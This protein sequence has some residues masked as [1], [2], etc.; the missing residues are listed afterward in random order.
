MENGTIKPI[1]GKFA[2][3]RS[4][5]TSFLK[6]LQ[7]ALYF[8]GG[9][10]PRGDNDLWGLQFRNTSTRGRNLFYYDGS[11]IYVS[12]VNKTAWKYGCDGGSPHLYPWENPSKLLLKYLVYIR[13]LEILLAEENPNSVVEG[14]LAR[15]ASYVFQNFSQQLGT[16][17]FSSEMKVKTQRLLDLPHEGI[18]TRD[19]RQSQVFI[20]RRY[21]LPAM[22]DPDN[23]YAA[24]LDI[25]A[26]HS[27]MIADSMYGVE[28]RTAPFSVDSNKYMRFKVLCYS[29]HQFFEIADQFDCKLIS[30]EGIRLT[31]IRLSPLQ[32]GGRFTSCTF[33]QT[34]HNSTSYHLVSTIHP[35]QDQKPTSGGRL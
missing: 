16:S 19:I 35:I 12:Y 13:P 20:G 2:E 25:Q 28:V 3:Y 34:H 4:M 24:I 8:T 33:R 7:A 22:R 21:I 15:M 6:S 9:Q 14:S 1:P 5:T 30:L 32:N 18:T 29:H 26:G 11:V 27:S 17:H 23:G 31:L 10:P